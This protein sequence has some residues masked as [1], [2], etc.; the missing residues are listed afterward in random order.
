MDA[1]KGKV[2]NSNKMKTY[3][4]GNNGYISPFNNGYLGNIKA[5][6]ETIDFD[7]DNDI[8]NEKT[9]EK[10]TPIKYTKS[11]WDSR[12]NLALYLNSNGFNISAKDISNYGSSN[13]N[14]KVSGSVTID[15][16]RYIINSNGIAKSFDVKYKYD[17][18]GEYAFNLNDIMYS[19]DTFATFL[20]SK[21]IIKDASELSSF[22]NNGDNTGIFLLKDGRFASVYSDSIVEGTYNVNDMIIADNIFY[23]HKKLAVYLEYLGVISSEDEILST[24]YSNN[25]KEITLKDGRKYCLTDNGLEKSFNTWFSVDSFNENDE[26]AFKLDDIMYSKETLATFLI[27]KGIIQNIDEI[28]AFNNNGNNNGGF[29]LENGRYFDIQSITSFGVVTITE[30]YNLRNDYISLMDKSGIYSYNN[31]PIHKYGGNQGDFAADNDDDTVYELL[32]NDYIVSKLKKIYPD[33][34]MEDYEAY[35]SKINNVGCGY[36]ALANCIFKSFENIPTEFEKRFG[37]PM[38][39]TDESGNKIMNYENLI[40]DYFTYVWA[41]GSGYSIDQIVNGPQTSENV[42]NYNGRAQIDEEGAHGTSP[43]MLKV[44]SEFMEKNYNLKV[45]IDYKDGIANDE[46]VEKVKA[47]KQKNDMPIIW[48]DGYNLSCLNGNNYLYDGGSHAM[49]A[50]NVTPDNE[51]IVSTWG[52]PYIIDVSDVDKNVNEDNYISLLDVNVHMPYIV[53]KS[54]EALQKEFITG[55]E[56]QLNHRNNINLGE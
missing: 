20:I 16:E 45:D 7:T 47:I 33:A 44:F 25:F 38:Y 55:F 21:G 12:D 50:T 17:K 35:L 9:E 39:Y 2:N 14:G 56:N 11:I 26:N 37:Y 31:Y 3:A 13:V 8:E 10:V 22:C 40:F 18:E 54:K 5:E 27:S 36:V 49:C 48:A 46:L 28:A 30:N 52:D 15:G 53:P 34:T 19:K 1:I 6:V 23:D 4:E 29:Y 41:D 24:S 42:P 43:N 51:I 32:Q